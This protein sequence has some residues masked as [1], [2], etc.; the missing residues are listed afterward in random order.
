MS[1]RNKLCV[2]ILAAGSSSRMG[3]PKQLLAWKNTSLLGHAISQAK[4]VSDDVF[5]I[6][7]ANANDIRSTIGNDVVVI[8]NPNWEKGMGTSIALGV[9][10]LIALY[11]FE[12][13]LI[14]LADQ[15]LLEAPYLLG[16]KENFLGSEYKIV[17]TSYGLKNGVPAVFDA[18]LF[19]DLSVLNEDYGARKLMEAYSDSLKTIDPNGK[20]IDIDTPD[21]YQQLL[22]QN[23]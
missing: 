1:N 14:M 6:L 3:S 21:T 23:V 19:A 4:Q 8:E 18:S 9:R 20:A 17:A 2:L 10:K 11:S 16:L 7:G 5:V 13:V 22:N 15:P 12:A